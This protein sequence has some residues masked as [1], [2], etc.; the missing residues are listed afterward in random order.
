MTN[1]EKILREQMGSKN[2]FRVPEGYFEH[3]TDKVMQRLPEDTVPVAQTVQMV[4]TTTH[5]GRSTTLLRRLRPLFYAA[6]CLVV[7]IFGFTLFFNKT[8][9]E[10]QP[11]QVSLA[12]AQQTDTQASDEYI[13]EA[14]DYAMLDNQDI[15]YLLADM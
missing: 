4:P 7:A 1:E 11:Q 5:N 14:V 6:A 15:Y 2:P 10:E 13:E 9:E 8:I 3:L 12:N